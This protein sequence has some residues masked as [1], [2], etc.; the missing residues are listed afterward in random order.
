MKTVRVTHF[1]FV[2]AKLFALWRKQF[3]GSVGD[4]KAMQPKVT[5]EKTPNR[6]GGPHFFGFQPPKKFVGS[7]PPCRTVNRAGRFFHGDG[8]TDEA[9]IAR[10]GTVCRSLR[11]HL[12]S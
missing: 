11:R 6:A 8:E 10:G 12:G 1:S 5:V 2:F 7:L 9:D 3:L 4:R